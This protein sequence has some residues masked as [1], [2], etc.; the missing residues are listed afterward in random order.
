MST[1]AA[2]LWLANAAVC[3]GILWGCI[4]RLRITT[5]ATRRPVRLQFVLLAAAAG[6]ST[7]QPWLV[8]E[9]PGIADLVLSSSIAAGLY[10][11][12]RRWRLSPPAETDTGPT[13]FDDLPHVSG[14]NRR[15]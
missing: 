13:P 8:G 9:L 6:F 4:C 7:L 3:A 14:G 2:L 5:R 12:R 1:T 11:G 15:T 10:I